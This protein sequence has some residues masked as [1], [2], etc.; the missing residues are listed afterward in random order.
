[1]VFLFLSKK[2]GGRFLKDRG[3]VKL[4]YMYFFKSE[5]G[6]YKIKVTLDNQA[7]EIDL[8]TNDADVALG[9]LQY[10]IFD[11]YQMNIRDELGYKRLV[12][13]YDKK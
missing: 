10:A 12:I 11:F 4:A 7:K 1:V 13:S 9:M 8:S 2:K 5:G 3:K 6:N